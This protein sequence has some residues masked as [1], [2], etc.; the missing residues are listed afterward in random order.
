MQS[1]SETLQVIASSC[2]NDNEQCLYDHK[3][4][5]TEQYTVAKSHF[6]KLLISCTSAW[7]GKDNTHPSWG[8][9]GVL[10]HH[11]LSLLSPTFASAGREA[12]M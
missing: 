5:D 1:I 10:N 3:T 4:T 2:D 8:G 6:Y 11:I 12:V 9:L 7:P